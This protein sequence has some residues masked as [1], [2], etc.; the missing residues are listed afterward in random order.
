MNNYNSL[1][2]VIAGINGTAI[3]RLT[4]THELVRPE[5]RKNFMRMELLMGTHKGHT[6]Y[7]L[8]WE[9]TRTERIPAIPVLRRDLVSADEGNKTFLEDGRINWNKFQ[10]MGE[11][12][13]H[14]TQSQE[15]PHK[16][17]LVCPMVGRMLQEAALT[18]DEDVSIP[19]HCTG[20]CKECA[21]ADVGNRNST[22]EA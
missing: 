17:V 4:A 3:H 11:I 8:A 6:K 19:L 5:V 1:A 20:I 9:N 14:I 21:E 22:R 12:V 18:V 2:A 15:N 10:V 7:R 13:Q 16:V